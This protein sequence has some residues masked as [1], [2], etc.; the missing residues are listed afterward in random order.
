MASIATIRTWGE[1]IKFSHSVFALPFAMIATFLAGRRLDGGLPTGTQFALIILCMVA[2]RSFAMTFNRIADAAIDA[3]NPRT[4]GRPIQTGRI[5]V[6]QASVFLVVSAAAFLAAC[7]GFLVFCQNPWPLYLAGPTLIVLAAYS[8]AK[9]ITA[10]THFILGATIAFAPMAAWIAIHPGSLGLSALLLTGIVLLWIAG[11]DI[12]Y[13]CQDI[14]IDRRDGLY[15][16]PARFGVTTAL[17]ISRCLHFLAVALLLLLAL[18]AGLGPLYLAA[19][20]CAAGL[21]VWQHRLVKNGD[22][23]HIGFAFATLNGGVSL[24]LAAAGI[25]DLL[26]QH[27]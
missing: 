26:I 12:I 15:S 10:L 27:V 6:A 16:I 24:L 13:A 5:S 14:D 20:F 18:P 22:M 11:F 21:L 25:T 17:T 19:L 1:M 3:R 2:A 9:R 4:A 23:S 8:Y 7:S